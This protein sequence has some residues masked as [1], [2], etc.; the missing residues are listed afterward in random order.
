MLLYSLCKLDPRIKLDKEDLDKW[1]FK[2]ASIIDGYV[3]LTLSEGK[4]A[5]LHRLILD[6]VGQI[7]HKNRDKLD[8]RKENL[9][10]ALHANNAHNVE[11]R[12][13]NTSG[14]KGVCWNNNANKWQAQIRV[15]R[16]RLYLGLYKNIEDAVRSYNKA[17][18]K[19]H[20]EFA[21][22]NQI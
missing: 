15:N 1:G 21:C 2:T 10:E 16:K 4:Q 8:C 20:G 22:L 17:A 19:Y 18:E 14:Y 11:L 9:R 7:D 6:T 12:S 13:T 3:V 5:R